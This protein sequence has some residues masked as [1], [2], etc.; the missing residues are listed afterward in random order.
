MHSPPQQRV[1]VRTD[2]GTNIFNFIMH[3]AHELC[4]SNFSEHDPQIRWQLQTPWKLQFL[5]HSA[6]W[7]PPCGHLALNLYFGCDSRATAVHILFCATYSSNFFP[8]VTS[9]VALSGIVW[10]ILN[11]TVLNTKKSYSIL[12]LSRDE[13]IFEG[14]RLKLC[15]FTV[16]F[17]WCLVCVCLLF[18]SCSRHLS[19]NRDGQGSFAASPLLENQIQM[20]WCIYSVHHIR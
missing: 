8:T 14:Y 6:S 12:Q 15:Y 4:H 16:H 7:A 1:I 2:A 10:P 18:L 11:A 3:Q 5:S 13:F 17:S 20:W 9:V 19:G